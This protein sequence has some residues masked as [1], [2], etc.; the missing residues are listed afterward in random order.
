MLEYENFITQ[1]TTM[2]T[3]YAYSIVY[4]EKDNSMKHMISHCWA[5]SQQEA[6]GWAHE[7]F[8]EDYTECKILSLLI[9]EIAADSAANTDVEQPRITPEFTLKPNF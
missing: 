1:G 7:Q 8:E 3:V 2:K 5:T 6:R 4:R 9:R